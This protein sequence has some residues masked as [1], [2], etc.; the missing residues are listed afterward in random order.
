MEKG[1]FLDRD[2]TII[3]EANYLSRPEQLRLIPGAAEGIALARKNGYRIIV[4]SNQSGI[5]RG[6]FTMEDLLRVEKALGDGA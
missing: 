6:Y 4:I 1:F 2:G 5:A 3:E